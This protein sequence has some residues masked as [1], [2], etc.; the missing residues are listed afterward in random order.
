[1]SHSNHI[2]IDC[3]IK[4]NLRIDKKGGSRYK[5][6]RDSYGQVIN[7]WHDDE[8]EKIS[9]NARRKAKRYAVKFKKITARAKTGKDTSGIRFEWSQIWHTNRQCQSPEMILIRKGI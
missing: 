7:V 3:V 6:E 4:H 8:P 1:M 9:K 5:I 2:E